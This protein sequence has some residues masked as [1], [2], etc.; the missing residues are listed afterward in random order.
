MK[1]DDLPRSPQKI[2]AKRF[3]SVSPALTDLSHLYQTEFVRSARAIGVLWA[4]CTLCLAIIEVVILVQPSWI[5]TADTGRY[6]PA[7]PSGTLG[8]F[9]VC[10]ES[11]WPVLDCRGGLSS[12]SPLPSF[13]SVAVLVGVSLWTVWTSLLCL[14]LFR[15]CSAATVYKICAWL[16]LTAGQSMIQYLNHAGTDSLVCSFLSDVICL[17]S[18]CSICEVSYFFLFR[19]LSCIGLSP[20]SRLMGQSRN[21]V[22]VWPY[23]KSKPQYSIHHLL[24]TVEP[25]DTSTSTYE[26]FG[27]TS[28]QIRRAN[29][30]L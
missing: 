15:F 12:L 5:G 24:I 26:Y 20:V 25:G 23:S 7:A 13:Q 1:A 16:Q 8:L 17:K 2:L 6:H 3:M 10:I 19:F 4:I 28:E 22:L 30:G 11:D 27:E 9:E 18:V 29:F 14:C 21:E